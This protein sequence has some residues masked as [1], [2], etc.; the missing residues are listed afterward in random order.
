MK[1]MNR[2]IFLALVVAG[3]VMG[4]NAFGAGQKAAEAPGG[5]V[6]S[7]T[8][9]PVVEQPVTVKIA[10]VKRDE[11][12]KD[13]S[14]MQVF[15]ELTE[16]SNVVVEWDI[17]E[18]QGWEEKKNLYFASGDLPDAF[19]GSEIL[20]MSDLV[21]YGPQGLLIPIEDMIGPYTPYLNEI[22]SKRPNFR[23]ELVTPDGHIYAL[24]SFRETKAAVAHDTFFIN[25]QWVKNVGMSLP[26][27]SE[28]FYQ[29]LKAFKEQDANKNG[30]PND[31]IPWSF[32]YDHDNI[33]IASLWGMFGILV[34]N[35][36][37]YMYVK[38]GVPVFSMA[39]PEYKEGLLYFRKLHSEG[40][41]D[42]EAFTHT[43]KI[44]KSKMTD[45][46]LGAFTLWF[47]GPFGNDPQKEE[48]TALAPLEG[49]HGDRMWNEWPDE[50]GVKDKG[51]FAITS[52]AQCPEVLM[53][54]ADLHYEGK[55]SMEMF[56]GP[57]GLNLEEKADGIIVDAPLPEGMSVG[58][59]R[60][61]EC[62]GSHALY[63][64]LAED[65]ERK[66]LD[67]NTEQ[68]LGWIN[69]LY[70]PCFPEP[71][72][73][74]YPRVFY[75]PEENKELAFYKTDIFSYAL[76]QTAK[77][78]TKG[79]IEEGWDDYIAKLEEMGLDG[80]MKIYR[81]AYDRYKAAQ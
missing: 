10:A 37:D 67:G 59:F 21:R 46:R 72:D 63:G 62:P 19:Y 53:R 25:Q 36:R 12:T 13:Y 52:S 64:I 56:W 51:A 35:A 77:W 47:L 73:E 31:E 32:L 40:L 28:D 5:I 38:D 42:P 7:K 24:P 45:F 23:G 74:V 33:G 11:V 18:E 75:T 26:E 8:G 65:Y 29:V 81:D 27:T 60:H 34:T 43:N 76:E 39:R 48:L 14:E 80:M 54:W 66:P 44:L 16:V 1:V 22:L 70:E 15:E 71:P 50:Y 20:T 41:I 30:D 58:E 2:R 4:M 69:T 17:S 6:V 61:S 9:I 3:L 79:G 78:I 68:K 49:P 55:R 57:F